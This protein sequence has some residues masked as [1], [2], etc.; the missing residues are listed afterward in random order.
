MTLTLIDGSGNPTGQTAVTDSA[1][2][3][4]FANLMPGDYG[5]TE[6]QPAGYLDG[7]DA[8]GTAGGTA[9]NPGDRSTAST[10]AGNQS[11]LN[12]DFGELLPASLS[13]YVYVDANNNGVFDSGE[14]PISGVVLTLLDGGG[15]STGKTAT[16]DS[17]GYYHFDNLAPGT[18][19]ASETQ[20][21]GYLDGLDA[22]GPVGGT[23]HNPGDLIDGITLAGGTSATQNNFG[24]LLPASIA[25]RVFV[26]NNQNDTYDAGEPLLGGVTI[27]LLDGS[28]NRITSTTTNSSGKYSF[29]NLKPGVYGVEEI[30]P[31]GYLEGSDQVGSAGGQLS[32]PDKILSAQLSSG[33][34]G[35]SYDFWEVV[36]AKISGYVFQDGP[37]IVLKRERSRAEHPLDPRRPA[38][39]GRQAALGRDAATL[40]RQRLS[41]DRRQR[42]PHH[43]EDRRQRLLRVHHAAARQL[44]GH[45]NSARR[46]SARH[47]HRRQPGRLVVNKY[48]TVDAMTLSTL[49]VD[50][51]GSAIVRISVDPG[52]TAVQYNFSEV[53]ITRQTNPPPTPTRR[54]SAAGLSDAVPAAARIAPPFVPYQPPGIVLSSTRRRRSSSSASAARADRSAITIGT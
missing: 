21:T 50:P 17:T 49:A 38:H 20:P 16:T 28:G 13:G 30:Q 45:R 24:E 53:L 26:D 10:S 42:Q 41:D 15:K 6:Q 36:P 39:A 5:V 11:G 7:L 18:Y 43:D 32:G 35:I 25:G 40:R 54:R 12:Y 48:S 52:D 1:G 23:A 3:Y 19:G 4:R 34:N 22:A 9:H 33:V 47:R 29:T 14:T 2:F 37:T 31:S 44:F 27:W 46:L 51:S 8:A